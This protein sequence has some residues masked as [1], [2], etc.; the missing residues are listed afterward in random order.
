[1]THWKHLLGYLYHWF[2]I[3]L[4]CYHICYHIYHLFD[5]IS[6]LYL[7]FC[8]VHFGIYLY[9]GCLVYYFLSSFLGFRILCLKVIKFCLHI[10]FFIYSIF[11]STLP[12]ISNLC[13][14]LTRVGHTFTLFYLLFI[15]IISFA[16][17]FMIILQ[18][19]FK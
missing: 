7:Y 5:F 16:F 1:M 10:P 13:L 8:S 4:V 11:T 14:K 12:I 15:L 2:D 6:Y 19:I 9:S 17:H 3:Y 18:H